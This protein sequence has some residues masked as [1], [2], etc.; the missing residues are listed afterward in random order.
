[1]KRIHRIR[2]IALAFGSLVLAPAVTMAGDGAFTSR[3][4]AGVTVSAKDIELSGAGD[5]R[6]ER[7]GV[8]MQ[9]VVFLPGNTATTNDGPISLRVSFSEDRV[10]IEQLGRPERGEFL[11]NAT[12]VTGANSDVRLRFARVNG[13]LLLYWRETAEHSGQYAQGL[14]SIRTQELAA[15]CCGT[16]GIWRSPH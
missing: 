11:L 13:T 15:V 6:S 8:N 10:G 2:S 16:G 7:G 3:M 1:M 14:L 5:C 12:L 4:P 9:A